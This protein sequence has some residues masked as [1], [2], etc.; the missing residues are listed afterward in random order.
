MEPASLLASLRD[1]GRPG[2]AK[3]A[4]GLGV[5][6]Q[7]CRGPCLSHDHFS[8]ARFRFVDFKYVTIMGEGGPKRFVFYAPCVP[9]SNTAD[10]ISITRPRPTGVY[11][12]HANTNQATGHVKD[13]VNVLNF[14]TYILVHTPAQNSCQYFM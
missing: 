6:T 3:A 4:H 11:V 2:F 12:V 14:S 8:P 9:L 13:H 7:V 1:I 10:S 5:N